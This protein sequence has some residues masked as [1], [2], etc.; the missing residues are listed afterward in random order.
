MIIDKARDVKPTQLPLSKETQELLLT[1]LRKINS[2]FATTFSIRAHMEEIDISYQREGNRGNAHNKAKIANKYGDKKKLQDMTIPVVQPQVDSMQAYLAGVFLSG[3][4]IFGCVGDNKTEDVALMYEAIM[5]EN[6][7]HGGWVRE[8]SM[9]LKDGLKYNVCAAEVDWK[10]ETQYQLDGGSVQQVGQP[11]K[12]KTVTWQGNTIKRMDLYNSVWDTRCAPAKLHEHG[13]FFGFTEAMAATRL[14]QFIQDLDG[15]IASNVNDVLSGAV[16][17]ATA[18]NS[19]GGKFYVPQVNVDS[20]VPSPPDAI[21]WFQVAGLTS[22]STNS[23]PT[24]NAVTTY[25]LRIIPENFKMKVPQRNNPQIWKVIVVNNTH[26]IYAERQSNIHNWLP[27]IMGQ[28]LEDGLNYQTKSYAKNAETFQDVSTSIWNASLAAQRRSVYDRIFYDP[29]RIRKEDID[30]N[31]PI[32]RIPVKN[33]A[34]NKPVSEAYSHAS[35]SNDQ[36]GVVG[37]SLQIVGNMANIAQGSNPAQQ[38]QFVKG[39]KTRHE[40]ADVMGHSNDRQQTMALFLEAQ[41]FYPLKQILK[42]NIL[43]YSTNGQIFSYERRTNVDIDVLKL[44]QASIEFEVSDGM[45][46]ADRIISADTMQVVIQAVAASSQLQMEF[47]LVGLMVYYFKTQGARNIDQFKLT[48]EQQ[49]IKLQQMQQMAAAQQ[50]PA[51]QQPGQPM[52]PPQGM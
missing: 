7:K 27:I 50:P 11:I 19:V 24:I 21:D 29:S 20:L 14:K 16:D 3:N 41:F 35:F 44:R 34:Y 33:N 51:P 32:A 48:P 22:S 4:P 6:A 12:Q 26:I 42:L 49:K 2:F 8:L 39:N 45:L 46:P 40:Y 47:D 36:F 5:D 13:E 10:Q 15:R 37:Q 9:V 28:L 52:Q 25:Y 23:I 18:G 1:H 43:Q 30:S 38:G 31:N 17:F